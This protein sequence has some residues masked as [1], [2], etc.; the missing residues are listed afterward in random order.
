MGYINRVSKWRTK[1]FLSGAAWEGKNSGVSHNKNSKT[2]KSS[3]RSV[4]SDCQTQSIKNSFTP[5]Q[6]IEYHDEVRNAFDVSI[7]KWTYNFVIKNDWELCLN[8]KT[9]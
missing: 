6:P 5:T 9:F 4:L 3:Y 7:F 8:E 2:Y 1:W